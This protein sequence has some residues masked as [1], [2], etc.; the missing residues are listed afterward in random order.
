[1]PN[2]N[3]ADVAIGVCTFA[4]PQVL[5]TLLDR[6]TAIAATTEAR[7]VTVIVDDD[8]EQS[9]RATVE[10]FAEVF[11]GEVVYE[12]LGAGNISRARNTVLSIAGR[13]AE[14]VALTDD[15]CLPRMGWINELVRVQSRFDADIVTGHCVDHTPEGVEVWFTTD[16]WLALHPQPAD[17][18][19]VD[20]GWIKNCLLRLSAVRTHG[21]EFDVAF[22]RTGGEDAVF[23]ANTASSGL[24]HRHAASA[25]VD[26]WVPVERSGQGY[27]MLRALWFGNSGAAWGLAAGGALRWRTAARGVRRTMR[28]TCA[29]LARAAK[30][31]PVNWNF[32]SAMA[33]IGI[34][35]VLGAL[36]IRIR[37]S[38]INALAKRFRRP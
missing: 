38:T 21:L 35:E 7:L 1:V 26:E 2:G 3:R 23:F 10:R 22:G 25:V 19:E 9:A 32:E 33:L 4:R 15:D 31:E 30:R 14:F 27:Q 34:G 18:A 29:S 12:S 6:L 37:H 24:H 20:S 17:G 8:P 16:E 11:P 36:G 5:Q 13:H 28:H